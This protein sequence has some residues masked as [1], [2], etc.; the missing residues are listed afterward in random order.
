[1]PITQDRLIK[2]IN[3]ANAYQKWVDL[4]KAVVMPSIEGDLAIVA[5][6]LHR[7]PD[8]PLKTAFTMMMNRVLA[9]R[10]VLAENP[11]PPELFR[12]L[13]EE[14]SHFKINA[15][16]NTKQRNLKKLGRSM[17][18]PTRPKIIAGQIAPDLQ[19]AWDRYDAEQAALAAA[20]VNKDIDPAMDPNVKLPVHEMKKQEIDPELK[21]K[22]VAEAQEEMKT[23]NGIDDQGRPPGE[24]EP[25]NFIARKTNVPI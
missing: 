7:E 11:I 5:S 20:E 4:I 9:T 13:I 12:N 23:W 10:D 24:P 3:T 1:M 8:S 15:R 17:E 21:A 6:V 25:L 22:L 18:E 19:A 2:L 14:E 16:R